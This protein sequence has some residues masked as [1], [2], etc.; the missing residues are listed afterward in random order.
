MC[1]EVKNVNVLHIGEVAGLGG[2]QNWVCRVAEAQARRGYEVELMQP[3]WVDPASRVYAALPVHRWDLERVRNF[4]IIHSHGLGGYENRKIG[5]I[6]PKPIVHTYYGTILGIQIALRWFQNLV[7]WNGLTVPRNIVRE[8]MCGHAAHTVIAISPMVRS[9][10]QRFYGIRNE[11]VTVIPGGYSMDDDGASRASLRRALG[12][13]EFGFLFLFVGRAD[14]VKNFPAASAAFRRVRAQ[15]H[16]AYLV[17]AP[18][19]DSDMGEGT[20]G[21]ELPPQRM[22]A[23]YR[24]VD[25]LVHP[26]LYEGYSL[27]VHEALANG[28]PVI[29]GRNTGIADYCTHRTDA[30]ILPRK[31]GSGLVESLAEMMGSLI[32]SQDLRT[33]LGAEAARKFA[34]MDWD[35]VAAETEKVYSSL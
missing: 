35:W 2:L 12:L 4:D 7:A 18:K 30:L 24:C 31:R 17:V 11:K 20:V 33:T 9:E 27:A 13:P 34:V 6:A 32:G 28:L 26:G 23:L 16:D 22:N 15:F 5:K 25:A 29:V 8:A 3:P 1:F 10:I 21:V 19:Q 14:P